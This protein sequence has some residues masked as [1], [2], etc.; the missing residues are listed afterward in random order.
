MLS[1]VPWKAIPY[2]LL[3]SFCITA[4]AQKFSVVNLGTLG[5]KSSKAYAINDRGYIVGEAMTRKGSTSAFIWHNGTMRA[6]NASGSKK[7]RAVSINIKNYIVGDVLKNGVHRAC[8]WNHQTKYKLLSGIS[9]KRSFAAKI[10]DNGM[11][12]GTSAN[13]EGHI[14]GVLWQNEHMI[15]LGTLGGVE[16]RALGLNNR[17]QV[18][19]D[20]ETS[21]NDKNTHAFLWQQGKMTGIQPAYHMGG[22]S[23]GIDINKN[24]Y[25]LG[26]I[27]S[28]DDEVSFIGKHNRIKLL[29]SPEGLRS[30]R[31]RDINDR[32]VV[33]GNALDRNNASRAVMWKNNKAIDLNSLIPKRSGWRLSEALGVNDQGHI[34]GYG[35]FKGKVNAFLLKPL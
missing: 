14:H 4:R 22:N 29:P 7:S 33:V 30:F 23:Y 24:G 19:G 16:S 3:F 28:Q 11:I 35:T 13:A 1:I 20:S 5:G 15:D 31:A 27:Y 26:W 9:T 34:V 8:V 32:N 21:L 25:V 6:L 18:I 17:G 12:A 2:L 10:N